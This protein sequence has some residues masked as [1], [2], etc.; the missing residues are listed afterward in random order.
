MSNVLTEKML[1]PASAKGYRIDDAVP[2][3][4]TLAG[5]HIWRTVAAGADRF[6]AV[7]NFR[8]MKGDI[9][10]DEARKADPELEKVS[11]NWAYVIAPK[12]LKL[13]KKPKD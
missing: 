4:V 12:S 9:S 5:T 1:M 10:A 13:P 11:D 7:T 6:T 2:L 8:H 3:D